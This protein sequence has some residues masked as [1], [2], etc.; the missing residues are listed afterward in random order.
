MS[1]ASTE[2]KASRNSL[3]TLHPAALAMMCRTLE[4]LRVHLPNIDSDEDKAMFDAFRSL[5][6]HINIIE[7]DDGRIEAEV[8]GYF[9]AFCGSDAGDSWGGPVVARGGLEPPTP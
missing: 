3:V 7:H 6:D 2:A 9:S 8:F 4:I 5:I 1:N